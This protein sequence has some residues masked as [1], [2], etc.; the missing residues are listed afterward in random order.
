VPYVDVAGLAVWHQVTGD[1][2]AVVLLHGAFAGAASWDA[3]T[4][5]LAS[6]GYRVHAPER[7]GHAHTADVDGPLTYAVMAEDTIAYLEREIAG[8]AN[9]VGWSDGA[10]V[11]LLVAQSCPDLVDRLVLIGQYYN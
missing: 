11:G 5:A 2:P 10:V 7:R 1:G 4:P 3:Q 6:G 9:L 8:R